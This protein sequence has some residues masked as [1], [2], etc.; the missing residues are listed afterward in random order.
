M[1]SMK[2][3]DADMFFLASSVNVTIP[4]QGPP[5]GGL[6][7]NKDDAWTAFLEEREQMIHFWDSLGKPVMIMTGDLHNTQ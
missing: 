6:I 7:E 1:D 4:H 3:S 2:K 5:G